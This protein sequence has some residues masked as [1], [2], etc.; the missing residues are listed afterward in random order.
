MLVIHLDA[1]GLKQNQL[2]RNVTS[3]I[4]M[5]YS[6][7]KSFE[8]SFFQCTYLTFFCFDFYEHARMRD[9]K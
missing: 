4:E 3:K 7:F 1:R 9:I 6:A 5:Q 8:F 2:R